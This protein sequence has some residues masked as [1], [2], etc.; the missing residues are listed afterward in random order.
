MLIPDPK[1]KIGDYVTD[2]LGYAGRVENI[3]AYR[4]SDKNY[5]YGLSPLDKNDHWGEFDESRLVLY[6]EKEKM[7]IC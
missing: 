2:R 1:F 6:I 7:K 4:F 3:L 5:I